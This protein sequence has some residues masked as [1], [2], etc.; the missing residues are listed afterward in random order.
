M[1]IDMTITPIPPELLAPVT[2]LKR[3][4]KAVA[5]GLDRDQA[6]GLVDMYYRFQEHRIAMRGQIRAIDQGADPNAATDVLIHFAD[7]VEVLEKQMVGA[8]DAWTDG[9]E[10]GRWAKSQVGIGPVLAAGLSAHIDIERAATAGAIWRFAGLDPSVKWEKG[11]KR[12]WNADLKLL[13]WKIGD[14]FVKVSGRPNGFYG[15]LYR[16]RKEYEL[17]RD[18]TGGNADAATKSLTDRAIKDKDLRTTLES[19]HLPAGQLDLRARRY[20]TKLFLAAWHEVA[21]VA[22]YDRL[23]PLPYAL[24][25]LDHTHEIVAPDLPERVMELRREAGRAW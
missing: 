16:S 23:P 1:T 18:V 11:K 17:E 22:H 20:A 9:H 25:H 2:K 3:E 14:S 7:Q 15:H 10:V 4:V 13:C 6:R 12:P 19:G 8:L 21:Y 5:T 24:A